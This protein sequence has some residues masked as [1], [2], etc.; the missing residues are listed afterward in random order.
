MGQLTVGDHRILLRSI[1]LIPKTF[2]D[3][4][5]KLDFGRVAPFA[6]PI[7]FESPGLLHDPY[8][9]PAGNPIDPLSGSAL[10]HSV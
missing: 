2:D 10:L 1:V 7:R 3:S 4:M 9:L 5:L 6:S 8:P